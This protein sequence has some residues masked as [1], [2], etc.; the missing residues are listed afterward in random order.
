[1]SPFRIIPDKFVF[2]NKQL[3]LMAKAKT[4]GKIEPH[5]FKKGNQ[6]Y[7]LRKVELMY[8]PDDFLDIAQEYFDWAAANPITV[9]ENLGTKN[10]NDV[11]K[12]RPLSITSFCVYAGIST[13]TFYSYEKKGT[14]YADA[15]L[16]IRDV[17]ECQQ[18]DHALVGQF[19]EN[20]V[21]R[22]N[23]IADKQDVDLIGMDWENRKREWH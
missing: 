21:S 19:K 12:V 1:M 14:E 17:I 5:R 3:Y 22:L 16:R 9:N 7:K 23:K 4:T 20:L 8:K 6:F 11:T 18:V 2:N 15:L 13:Q 10:V